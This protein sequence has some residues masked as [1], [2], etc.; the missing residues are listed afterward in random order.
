MKLKTKNLRLKV[1]GL[2]ALFFM[3]GQASLYAQSPCQ[4]P[5]QIR[6]E[7]M[8]RADSVVVSWT[9]PDI[10]ITSWDIAYGDV[11]F[12]PDTASTII[13]GVWDTIYQL[14]YLQGGVVYQVYVRSDCGSGY[15]PWQGPVSFVPG[16]VVMR[17][18]SVGAVAQTVHLCG[19][20]V[21]DDGGRNGNYSAA[22]ASGAYSTVVVYP[23]DDSLITIHGTLSCYNS[24]SYGLYI[25]DGVGT[26][27]TLMGHYY[28][29]ATIP[30]MVSTQGPVTIRF[31]PYTG[32]TTYSGFELFVG[33]EPMPP[34]SPVAD[35]AIVRAPTAAYATWQL[36]NPAMGVPASYDV[37]LVDSTGNIQSLSTND[38][39]ALFD[40][41]NINE[42][43]LLRVQPMCDDG[44]YLD[45]DTTLFSTK[46]L[47]CSQISTSDTIM[48]GSGTSTTSSLP[49]AANYNYSFSEQL[50]M[51]SEFGTTSCDVV[52]IGFEYAYSSPT[53]AKNN[54]RI[55]MGHTTSSSLTGYV[56][57]ASQ[58]LVYSGPLNASAGWNYY[59]FNEAPFHYN[60][61]NNVVV[62]VED[63]SG[64]SNGS[65]YTFYGHAVNNRAVYYYSSS[66]L[67]GVPP[68]RYSSS[69][70]NNMQFLKCGIATT[71][72]APQVIVQ[73]TSHTGA[74]LL[75][76]PGYN[77]SSW[78]VSYRAAGDPAWTTEL[79]ATSAT[80]TTLVGLNPNT[81]YD[82]RVSHTC[83]GVTYTGTAQFTTPC[84]PAALPFAESFET[85]GTSGS[86]AAPACWRKVY[87]TTSASYMPYAT[88]SQAYDG[89]RSLYLGSLQGNYSGIVLPVLA[90]P[91][92]SLTLAFSLYRPDSLYE[93]NVLVGVIR[94][95]D[96][97]S[98]FRSLYSVAAPRT[99]WHQYELSLT[100]AAGMEGRLAIVTPQAQRST[101]YID[102]IEVDY[103]HTCPRPSIT[104]TYATADSIYLNW[105]SMA[106]SGYEVEYG[107]HGFVH[108]SGTVVQAGIDTS[109]AI[110]GLQ[111]A[112]TYDLYVRTLC[113]GGET[114]SWSYLA[115][116]TTQCGAVALPIDEDFDRWGTG[117]APMCWHCATYDGS[118]YQSGYPSVAQ[119]NSGGHTGPALHFRASG[120]NLRPFAMMPAADFSLTSV[121]QC[122]VS[123]DMIDMGNTSGAARLVV[124]V[125]S[126]LGDFTSF[127]PVDTITP[128]SSST[129]RH[130]T[131]QLNTYY[132][133]GEYVT[134]CAYST[135]SGTSSCS[136]YI[137]NVSLGRITNC[138]RVDSL[139][140]NAANA[141]TAT[142]GWRTPS[143]SAYLWEVSY[144]PVGSNT[145]TTVLAT[146]NPCTLSGLQPATDY[147]FNVRSICTT[148][149]TSYFALTPGSF[150]T[151]QIPATLPY[152]CDFESD[153]E[154]HN[155][156]TITNTDINWYRGTAAYSSPSHS[157]Y[158]SADGGVSN[159]T[160]AGTVNATAYRDIDFGS[161]D[162]N[163][164]LRF[165]V[166]VGGSTNGKYDGVGLFLEDPATPLV[167]GNSLLL[168]PWGSLTG[169]HT[170]IEIIQMDTVWTEHTYYFDTVQGP[171]R[172][173]FYWYNQSMNTG[174][175]GRFVG[176][177]G[178]IDD[179]RINYNTCHQPTGL[180]LGTV[181][182][183]SASVTWNAVAGASYIFEY[184]VLGSHNPSA[185][186]LSSGSYTM[187][188]LRSGTT[189]RCRVRRSCSAD[190]SGWT[191]Y[192]YFNTDLCTGTHYDTLIGSGT[193]TT[194]NSYPISM[195]NAYSFT[196]M[197]YLASELQGPANVGQIQFS[198]AS[199]KP[200]L[201]RTNCTIYMG[202]T[203][204]RT[205]P[206]TG[207]YVP[208]DS[209]RMVYCG[210]IAFAHGWCCVVLDSQFVY[211]GID[212]L[213][214]AVDDNTGTISG[215]SNM[216]G[217]TLRS[218]SMVLQFYHDGYNPDP[219]NLGN[220]QGQRNGSSARPNIV[221]GSCGV[222]CAPP[223][224]NRATV[225]HEQA[226]LS[227][228]ANGNAFEFACKPSNA[229]NWPAATSLTD[230][231]TTVTSLSAL[232][233]YDYRV[234]LSC[235]GGTFSEWRYGTFT[236]TDAPCLEPTNVRRFGAT[237]TSVTVAWDRGGTENLWV[238]RLTNNS[239]AAIDTVDALMATF[240][241]LQSGES[242]N[243]MVRSLCVRH[244]DTVAG[245]WT[246]PVAVTTSVCRPVSDLRLRRSTDT[247]VTI[248]WTR[249]SNNTGTWEVQYGQHGFTPG[250]GGT[251]SVTTDNPVTITG[252]TP[253]YNLDF[254]VRAICDTDYV[255]EWSDPVH[256]S[257]GGS[258]ANPA[259]ADA[260]QVTLLPNPARDNTT[261]TI[262][263]IEGEVTLT[264]L[265]MAGR[266]LATHQ[267]LCQ[268]N[269]NQLL[270]LGN[271]PAD[272]YF[273]RITT[274]TATHTSKLVISR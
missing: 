124:G 27:G 97:F 205:L 185:V 270:N 48:V 136:V 78:D 271:L 76:L 141:T 21:Y 170:C 11:G 36:L 147:S 188:Q 266:T 179:I 31:E 72:G 133:S 273:I 211:N 224:L 267:L 50:I 235:S 107:R 247:S 210:P 120:T 137:D 125:S 215:Q 85:W 240:E 70:R 101:P 126:L 236:T 113:Y 230:T 268:G 98:T 181:G 64:N 248:G 250:S 74:S 249:G 264:L 57:L 110:G 33:C 18:P 112:T 212:N 218:Q 193:A 222:P 128:A 160:R 176:L 228:R 115:S 2:L 67:N 62:T 77:E 168:S 149:D 256:A 151:L 28:G 82:V 263:N 86:A 237:R 39:E 117:S 269:C 221:L 44:S 159:S 111:P 63:L 173:G 96:N 90:A 260:P 134:F 272:T 32:S 81:R 142:I 60:G 68:S 178:A 56:S 103:Y 129:M 122:E 4:Q 16:S 182:A 258:S 114:S 195:T 45:W 41:L 242:Y 140:S 71:C 121:N 152:R 95:P 254:Y 174:T 209:L 93:H 87:N 43:Y 119:L 94:D 262:A 135:V 183:T 225:T 22:P 10:T 226:R 220:Y 204:R 238:A 233:S 37:E 104:G 161:V 47:I 105:S 83:Q 207:I 99:G 65:A 191:D 51:A 79:T 132:G 23:V 154:S 35:V 5:T 197:L 192:Q 116:V 58:T 42:P 213:I 265:D 8:E 123:F 88:S 257:R 148:G 208:A 241:G 255:S 169:N 127:T 153:T 130:Y 55:Y 198:L 84:T 252:L 89:S 138:R 29:N 167:T 69:T 155:W 156:Q 259:D 163:V 162:T 73:S 206:N 190:T 261:I 15:S 164:V 143:G 14:P 54:V 13:Y 274:P 102:G 217:A 165:K 17:R 7:S 38:R 231:F 189:Y 229:G 19:G 232:T 199:A 52:G 172:L 24:S 227:W 234:R 196:E 108:D 184:E 187:Q 202:H 223:S 59:L 49:V 175:T 61:H 92:D 20:A 144:Q 177:P 180:C 6:I 201:S 91:L 245:D 100:A 118:G 251:S 3:A 139:Y 214:V 194:S 66:P 106:A 53:T 1:V 145:P 150:S 30:R 246:D 40:N 157:L 186:A 9:T 200:L 109:F 12:D 75:W 253:G 244:G 26:G 171:H 243:V 131:V 46:E 216:F 219:Y 80:S 203:W 239:H 158:V 25:Y 146:S 166:R 34:C